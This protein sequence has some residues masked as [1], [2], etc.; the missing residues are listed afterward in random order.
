M[1]GN[2]AE[3]EQHRRALEKYL[4]DAENEAKLLLD[5]INSIEDFSVKEIFMLRY[6]DGVRPWQKVAFMA[7]EYDESYVRRKHNK[8]LRK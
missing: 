4:A 8:Q 6:Y 1:L 5:Y 3:G 2:S 7:G